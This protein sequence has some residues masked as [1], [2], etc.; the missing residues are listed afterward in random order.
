MLSVRAHGSVGQFTWLGKP[1]RRR[2][3]GITESEFL[4]DRQMDL[5]LEHG[6]R[7]FVFFDNIGLIG[8]DCGEVDMLKGRIRRE[9]HARGLLTH[10]LCRAARCCCILGIEL[11]GERLRT[12][13]AS[14][15]Y[16]KL[17][18]TLHWILGKKR[19]SGRML[20]WDT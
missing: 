5:C 15:K 6:P 12:R 2:S 3:I 9:L 7:R 19:V 18:L 14:T 10:E 17:R 8:K 11:D 1:R 16:E 13:A 20:E 4:H